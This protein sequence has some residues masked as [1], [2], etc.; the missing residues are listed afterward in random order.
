MN[1]PNP[2]EPAPV[3]RKECAWCRTEMRPG[4]EPTSHGICPTCAEK[5]ET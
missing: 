4:V 1:Q 2:P 3:N 5:L